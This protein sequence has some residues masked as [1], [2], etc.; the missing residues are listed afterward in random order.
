MNADILVAFARLKYIY[1]LLGDEY[2]ARAYDNILDKIIQLKYELKD[3]PTRINATTNMKN[4]IQ[5]FY[6]T[7]KIS[8]LEE[9]KNSVR[10][11]AYVTFTL[12][13]G[14]GPAMAKELINKKIYTLSDLRKAVGKKTIKLTTMQ[15]LGLKYAGRIN[16]AIPHSMV[17]EIAKMLMGNANYTIAGSYRRM[18][19]FSSDI[20]II[21]HD[22]DYEINHPSIIEVVTTG[23]RYTFL[24]K[25][26]EMIIQVD[27]IYSNS[28]A[29]LLYFTGS[30]E[31]NIRLRKIAKE[32]GYKLNQDG[33]WKDGKSVKLKDEADIFKKLKLEYVAPKFRI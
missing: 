12:M 19:A 1:S 26:K 18:K 30:K 7:G 4:K 14:F 21:C 32:A 20:D 6:N 28:P 17:C 33:L 23:E 31:F 2:R 8:E 22:L 16:R 24:C 9:L 15:T 13:M 27:V 5:E 3:D 29:T 25:W 10:Y 11:Q